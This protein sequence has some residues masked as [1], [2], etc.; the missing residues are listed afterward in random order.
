MSDVTLNDAGWWQRFWSRVA[1]RR[2]KL[3]PGSRVEPFSS[4][5][6]RAGSVVDVDTAL[7]I[8][9]VWACV[10]LK[11]QT[12]SS[13]PL[14]LRDQDNKIAHGH[15]IYRL[16]HKAPNA[17]MGPSEF[18]EVI[19]SSLDLWGNFYA[20]I[21]RSGSRIISLEILS[22]EEMTVERTKSGV[23]RYVYKEDE[24]FSE[25]DILHIRGFTLDGLVGL[26]PIQYAAQTLGAQMDANNAADREFAS[27]LKTGLVIE[28]GER[29]LQPEQRE[30]L[31]RNLREYSLPEK[32]NEPIVLEAGQKISNI[33]GL[34][35]NPADAQLLESRYFGIEEICRAFGVPPQLIGHT[36]KASSWASSLEQT[37]MGFLTY[38]LQPM[39]VRIEQ[40]MQRKLLI[41]SERDLYTAKF[42]VEG[43]L[44]SDSQSRASFYASMLQNGVM[45]RNEVRALENLPSVDGADDLTIQLNLT[46]VD[47]VGKEDEN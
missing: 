31:R 27:G 36:D 7:K 24:I 18:K 29:I 13:L 3:D 22:A 15:N 39:L 2:P 40:T 11:A 41:P 14:H 47:K 37:N 34:K 35:M 6:S 28:S 10:R 25:A 19:S 8:A 44:R 4:Y 12:I 21:V 46:P 5:R 16:L 1:G 20:Q 9:S 45:T 38:G 33:N 30:R 42:S 23:I 26:S 43:L 17:D 32:T